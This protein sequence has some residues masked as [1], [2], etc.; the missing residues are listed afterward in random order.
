MTISQILHIAFAVTELTRSQ[1]F[2][3]DVLGL[4]LVE[5]PLN[6]PGVW[7]QIGRQQL[8]LIQVDRIIPDQ[9]NAEKWGRNRHLAFGIADL[10]D[11]RQKLER[12]HIPIQL[13]A[14]GRAAL[15]IRDPDGNIIELTEIT[16]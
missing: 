11:I 5:R 12:H 2:Y 3:E 8:H 1:Q 9:V 13:S 6:F 10:G 14:S 16:S 15:F 7:Y 4:T